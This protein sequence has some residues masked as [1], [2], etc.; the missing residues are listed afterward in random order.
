[1]TCMNLICCLLLGQRIQTD[2]PRPQARRL[3]SLTAITDNQ[4]VLHG[5]MKSADVVLNDTWIMDL[6][7]KTWRKHESDQDHPRFG[8]TGSVGINKSIIIIGGCET[9]ARTSA[10]AHL[11]S[12]T[13]HVRFEPKSL[14]QLAMQT[15]Y[16]HQDVL[17]MEMP[18]PQSWF[19]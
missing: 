2:Q 11:Y 5:G 13:F 1:M 12:T 17:S 3:C 9:T 4:L 18:S 14:Q 19:I 16:E 7:S 10:S 15:V 8:H 6:S